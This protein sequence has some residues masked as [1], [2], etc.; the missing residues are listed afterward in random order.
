M[1]KMKYNI[2]PKERADNYSVL[3]SI[4]VSTSN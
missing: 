2:N 4:D 1:N 3:E